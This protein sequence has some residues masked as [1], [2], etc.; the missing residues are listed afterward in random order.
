MEG[1]EGAKRKLRKRENVENETGK[2]HEC[3]ERNEGIRRKK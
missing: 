3:K 2:K 1:K